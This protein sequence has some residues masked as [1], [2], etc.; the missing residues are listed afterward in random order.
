MAE[1]SSLPLTKGEGWGGGL[2]DRIN[3]EQ[4]DGPYSFPFFPSFPSKAWEREVFWRQELHQGISVLCLHVFK[5]ST[6]LGI[7]RQRR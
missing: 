1:H 2:N 5:R 4:P 6:K 3:K 7:R